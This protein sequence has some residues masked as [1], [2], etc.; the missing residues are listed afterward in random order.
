MAVTARFQSA[1][2]SDPGRKRGNN[3]DRF[4]CDPERGIYVVIDG[5][6]GQA[7]GERA[8]DIAVNVMKARLEREAG[9]PAERIREAIALAN[10]EIFSAASQKPEW[11]GMACVLTAAIAAE[12]RVTIGHVG[13]SR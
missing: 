3:E 8:A 9:T 2:L 6:G 11:H 7:A 12:D 4:Y 5:M 1:A 10:N 13:D